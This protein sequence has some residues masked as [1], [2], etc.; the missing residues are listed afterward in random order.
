MSLLL[1]SCSSDCHLSN[2]LVGPDDALTSSWKRDQVILIVGVAAMLISGIVAF[3]LANGKRK[4][5]KRISKTEE[6]EEGVAES[7]REDEETDG[8]VEVPSVRTMSKRN[9]RQSEFRTTRVKIYFQSN[10]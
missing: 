2:P 1:L 9:K 8:D 4:S 10:S 3:K 5:K 7:Y 6:G